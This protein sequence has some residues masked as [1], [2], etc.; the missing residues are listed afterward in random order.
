MST[1]TA[2]SEGRVDRQGR[3]LEAAL[4]LLSRHGISGVN[5]R[6]VAREAGVS[7][8][9]V[10]YHYDDKMSLIRAAL[11]RFE[12][13]DLGFLES[14]T[15]LPPVS[16]LRKALRRVADDEFLTTEY[17]SLRLQLWSLARAHEDFEEINAAAWAR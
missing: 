7:L 9:L 16:R 3:I 10:H 6:A 2:A 12:E 11:H 8:G 5:M 1:P 14:D 15:E 17:L 4:D 13:Q